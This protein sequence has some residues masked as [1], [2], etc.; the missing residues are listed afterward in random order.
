[1]TIHRFPPILAGHKT[2][3]IENLRQSAEI[4]GSFVYGPPSLQGQLG[5]SNHNHHDRRFF[6]RFTARVAHPNVNQSAG[7]YL[8]TVAALLSKGAYAHPTMSVCRP[9][10]VMAAERP[11][12]ML[13][14][15]RIRRDSTRAA[16]TTVGPMHNTASLMETWVSEPP[17]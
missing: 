6:P 8:L 10:R 11:T 9:S 2:L 12:N 15:S 17:Q 5:A 1:M 14:L 3:C 16:T 7:I 4:C 13:S